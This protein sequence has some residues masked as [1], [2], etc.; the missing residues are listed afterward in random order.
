MATVSASGGPTLEIGK[1]TE[2]GPVTVKLAGPSVWDGST[3]LSNA[4]CI[5]TESTIKRSRIRGGKES[6]AKTRIVAV[7]LSVTWTATVSHG[8][9]GSIP[10]FLLRSRYARTVYRAGGKYGMVTSVRVGHR[11]VRAETVS[12]TNDSTVPRPPACQRPSRRRHPRAVWVDRPA[13]RKESRGPVFLI[14]PRRSRARQHDH[15]V[16]RVWGHPRRGRTPITSRCTRLRALHRVENQKERVERV[17]DWGRSLTTS[18]SEEHF[19]RR[20]SALP[21]S[22]MIAT[23]CGAAAA[24][25]ARRHSRRSTPSP[26]S[27]AAIS[28][29]KAPSLFL[30]AARAA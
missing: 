16:R 2:S 5:E 7:A 4:T 6:C 10:K 1:D 27:A 20:D 8:S 24:G 26:S 19:L 23:I 11:D 17:A 15:G 29:R 9:L 21:E 28:R 22:G 18:S 14:L 25:G 13:G 30:R 12:R 3:G